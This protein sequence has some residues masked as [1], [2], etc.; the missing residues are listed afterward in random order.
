MTGSKDKDTLDSLY[1]E[2]FEQA[3]NKAS[4]NG[5]DVPSAKVW[6]QIQTEIEQTPPPAAAASGSA[7]AWLAAS[8]SLIAILSFAWY[9]NQTKTSKTTTKVETTTETA[10]TATGVAP[11]AEI[12]T[13]P[14]TS[15]TETAK[16]K[17]APAEQKEERAKAIKTPKVA[18]QTP[19]VSPMLV[20]SAEKTS[21]ETA[22]NQAVVELPAPK[23]TKEKLEQ[24]AQT[25]ATNVEE[26]IE[27]TKEIKT[28]P[29]FLNNLDRIK[30]E[31]RDIE[32]M[33]KMRDLLV[34]LKA[35][36][37]PPVSL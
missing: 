31:A 8:V 29:R 22:V 36:P 19:K 14:E 32:A 3:P 7:W 2:A 20:P 12:A 37:I 34:P 28:K 1:K 30:A 13:I 16:I 26:T 25:Q 21:T 35:K 4:A 9:V 15:T 27:K 23:N 17:D 5:W 11:A 18:P 24:A 10:A 6:T 33:P